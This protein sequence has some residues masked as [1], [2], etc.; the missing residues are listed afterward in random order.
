MSEEVVEEYPTGAE[1]IPPATTLEKVYDAG[2]GVWVRKLIET[3]LLEDTF[4]FDRSTVDPWT[5]EGDSGG[6]YDSDE[7]GHPFEGS[8]N[9]K[10]VTHT[11]LNDTYGAY[12]LFGLTPSLKILFEGVFQFKSATDNKYVDFTFIYF[13]GTNL[14]EATL[15]Y[16]PVNQKW[17]YKNSA[18]SF[19][20][21]TSGGQKL[22]AQA[23][24]HVKITVDFD[25]NKYG[26]LLCDDKKFD[27][28]SISIYTT[29]DTIG[30]SGKFKY[31]TAT[32]TATVAAEAY[33][34][35]IK[36]VEIGTA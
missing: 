34:D 8:K 23:Y 4:E 32:A 33:L 13:D 17:Q 16:D 1:A 26:Y 7:T 22:R 19:V 30:V 18:G 24:H 14:H 31:A 27:L 9:L 15:R 12:R 35:R 2:K 3:V 6:S 21:I 25:N 36:I 29:G 28:T 11:D 10:V 20:D 5:G